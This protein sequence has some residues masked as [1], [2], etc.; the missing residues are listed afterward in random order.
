[1][2][3]LNLLNK[4]FGHWTVLERKLNSKEGSS[5]WICR[6]DCG[7]EYLVQRSNLISGNSTQ[8][9]I[10]ASKYKTPVKHSIKSKEKNRLS[11]LGNKSWNFKGRIKTTAGYIMIYM[12]NHPN[13]VGGRG[14]IYI[15]E[16]RLV[17]E[18]HLGRYLTRKEVVHHINGIRNDN[19]IE[20][21]I[22]FS[23]LSAHQNF[24]HLNKKT[25]ICKFCGKNQKEK[26]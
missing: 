15:S 13:S 14:G 5:M 21:L 26:L 9:R 18:K 19:R 6:C 24:I 4:K 8:C 23:N 25:F 1:M 7:R 16:H 10:C 17:M 3:V 12:P 11:H 22:L 20:N 2:K